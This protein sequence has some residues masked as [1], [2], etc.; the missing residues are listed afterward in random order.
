MPQSDTVVSSRV[1]FTLLE[2]CIVLAVIGI[3]ATD[4]SPTFGVREASAIA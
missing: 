1:A 3:L 4:L 2:I